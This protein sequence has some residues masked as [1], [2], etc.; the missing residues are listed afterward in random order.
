MRNLEEAKGFFAAR[1]KREPAP[2]PPNFWKNGPPK[3]FFSP[4]VWGGGIPARGGGFCPPGGKG[5]RKPAGGDWSKRRVSPKKAFRQ[6][7]S[8][9]RGAASAPWGKDG[10]L[11]G[12]GRTIVGVVSNVRMQGPFN[13]PPNVDATGFYVPFAASIFGPATP[14]PAA[15]QFATVLV[16]PRGATPASSLADALVRDMARIDSNLPLYFVAT[17]A[18][19]LDGVLG[20]NRVVATMFSIFGL[21]AVL[22]SAVGLYGVMS[23]SVNQRRQEFGTRMVLG[24]DRRKILKM[25]LKQGLVQ[26]AIGLGV[27]L[28]LALAIA[29]VGG[30]GIRRALF[31]V[32]P[33]DPVTYTLVSLLLASVA[34]V[35]TLVPAQRAT[36]VDPALALRSQ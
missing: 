13:G 18:A 23:F 7:R 2:K 15:P 30:D 20:Q 1:R 36:R 21:I 24:A 6:T 10:K 28:A 22:L 9:A 26:L 4:T 31:Q 14:E 27:G 19:N 25:V 11:F 3:G 32:D 8:P 34:F 33:R 12:P 17:P 16:R 35:A 5:T 29:Q